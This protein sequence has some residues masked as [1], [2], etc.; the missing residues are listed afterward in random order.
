M[1]KIPFVNLKK[2]YISLKN[3]IL[4]KIDEVLQSGIYIL[5]KNLE[6]F[7]KSLA[8]Y[9][10]VS[11]SLGVA[12]GSDAL[13]LALRAANIQPDDEVLLPAQSFIATAWT[14]ANLGAR[15][16]FVDIDDDYNISVEDLETKISNKT[17]FIVAV[18]LYGKI[19]KI[20]RIQKIAHEN[21]LIM[22]EDSAQAIGATYY[23][24]K[25]GSFGFCSA[26]SFHPLKVLHAYGDGGAVVT[27]DI[28][29]Y[30]F[31]V[32]YRNHGLKNRDESEFWGINSRLDEIQAAILII[33]LNKIEEYIQKN[34]KI[35]DF[36]NDHLSVINEIKVPLYDKTIER[37]NFHRY[38]I[39]AQRRNE[40]MG[41]LS[42]NGI[43]TKIHYPKLI[44]FQE[45]SKYLG[46]KKGDFPN[47][48]I[49]SEEILSL[50]LYP[51]LEDYEINFVVEKIKEFYDYK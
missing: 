37:P 36:Y 14:V 28:Q 1:I 45:C 18:H 33:K 27:N 41:F 10:N 43:E 44:P 19:C 7:E 5:G 11:Y 30:E 6:E 23:G 20:D 31:L 12:N 24:K 49:I 22:I 3:E 42:K 15:P 8:K 25:A 40:L 38:V 46:Y 48:E 16:V 39:R 9:C 26:F 17:K 51:E 32:K 35:A 29:T 34:L 13:T 50:P 47:A 21:G 2:Q 4:N